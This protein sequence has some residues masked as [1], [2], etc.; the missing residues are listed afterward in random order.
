MSSQR[1]AWCLMLACSLL[2]TGCAAGPQVAPTSIHA[3]TS[4]VVAPVSVR[5]VTPQDEAM[6]GQWNQLLQHGDF[7]QVMSTYGIIPKLEGQSGNVEAKA[8]KEHADELDAALRINPVGIALWYDAYR[9][10]KS[11][12]QKG[13]ASARLR[14]LT[15]VVGFALRSAPPDWGDTPIRV[16]HFDDIAAFIQASGQQ[17]ANIYVDRTDGSRYLPVTIVLLDP[18]PPHQRTFTFDLLDSAVR[19]QRDPDAQF[20]SFRNG[21][22]KAIVEA[23][24]RSGIPAFAQVLK[25]DDARADNDIKSKVKSLQEQS[26]QGSF[27]A[28]VTLARICLF[29]HDKN[30]GRGAVDA[31]LPWAEQHDP[32]AMLWLAVAYADGDGVKADAG[33]ARRLIEA[34]DRE[35][36]NNQ[37]AFLFASLREGSSGQIDPVVRDLIETQARAH[38]P[39]AEFVIAET[40]RNASK[41]QPLSPAV[42]AGLQHAAEFGLPEA[43]RLYGDELFDEH[44]KA[45]A[46]SWLLKAANTGDARAQLD[47][48]NRYAE[49][50][51][52]DPHGKQAMKVQELWRQWNTRAAQDGVVDVMLGLGSFYMNLPGGQGT[53]FQAQG[54]MQSAAQ[55]GSVDGSLSL[56]DIYATNAPGLD[57]DA[58]E[59]AK[60]Y[61]SVLDNDPNNPNAKM[62]LAE[63]LVY[64]NGVAKD[65]GEARR[66]RIEA[67]NTGNSD[68]QEV[69]GSDLLYGKSGP[70]NPKA[71]IGWLKKAMAQSNKLAAQDY[72][73]A[74]FNGYGVKRDTG[75]AIHLWQTALDQGYLTSIN[76]AA[77]NL[78]TTPD[79]TLFDPKRGMHFADALEQSFG[80]EATE[81]D[82]VAACHA[83]NGDFEG[84]IHIEEGAIAQAEQEL[85]VPTKMLGALQERKQLFKQHKRYT[86]PFL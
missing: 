23:L 10:A 8:C 25:L 70:K 20:P 38:E 17:L 69:L 5:A 40:A 74:L 22:A 52:S 21:M 65:L 7:N 50:F 81:L 44:Q 32:V 43:E 57:G 34:G 28:A 82:T 51:T 72:A 16:L 83:A 84:A 48:A 2:L 45:E 77:W 59:A 36:G 31:L 6:A 46:M 4:Y 39:H 42:R 12:Q 18:T 1:L 85:P 47:L 49:Q 78:C 62:G 24:A 61:Q 41:K 56:G 9:C 13:L 33:N 19:M 30:C 71:G 67:A 53:L 26:G 37:I 66:L 35:L 58:G 55:A 3:S 14:S 68:A 64:G 80:V 63:L 75:K 15:D 27:I 54:W 76:Q 86:E 29:N 79:P 73:D 60:I 11:L